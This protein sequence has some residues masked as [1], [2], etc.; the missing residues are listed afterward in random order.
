MTDYVKRLEKRFGSLETCSKFIDTVIRSQLCD[1]KAYYDD[2]YSNEWICS[3]LENGNKVYLNCGD[4]SEFIGAVSRE[5][6]LNFYI[7]LINCPVSKARHYITYV[8]NPDSKKFYYTDC[9]AIAD[10][11]ERYYNTWGDCWCD[12]HSV[13]KDLPLNTLID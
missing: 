8:Q 13:V 12:P 2:G 11:S 5:Y 7:S 1:Y 3:Q 4:F 10:K 9:S 6:G